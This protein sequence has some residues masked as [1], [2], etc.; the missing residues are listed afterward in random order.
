LDPG[1]P[2]GRRTVNR[3]RSTTFMLGILANDEQP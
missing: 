3:W 1:L 2:P